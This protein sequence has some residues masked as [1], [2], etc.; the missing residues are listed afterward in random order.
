LVQPDFALDATTV[1]AVAEI[2]RRLDGIPLAIELA[3]ARTKILSINELRR[4]LDDRFRLLVDGARTAPRRLQTLLA[5]IN[6]SFDLL[7]PNERQLLE[8]LSVFAGGWTLEGAVAVGGDGADQ[9]EVLNLLSRLVDKSLVVVEEDGERYRLLETIREYAREHLRAAGAEAAVR[10]RHAGWYVQL[11][12]RLEPSLLGGPLQ[13][14]ALD[15][16]EA[17]NDNLNAALAWSLETPEGADRAMRMCGALYRFWSRRGYWRE[18]YA[19]CTRALAQAPAAGDKA[20][21]AKVLLTA[22]S[23]GNNV[24][25]AET[26]VFLEAAVELG[27]ESGDR[28]TEAVALNNLARVLDWHLELSRARSLLEKARR[29]NRD[30]GNKIPELHNMSNLVNV[31]REQREFAA[32][33]ALAQE[34]LAASRTLGDRWLAAI[35]LYL[36]GRIALDGGQIAAAREFNEQALAIFRELAM[37]DWQSFSLAKLAFLAIA[38]GEP[39]AARRH[40]AEAVD[41]SRS[42][43]GRLNLAECIGTMGVL[44]S[45]IGEHHQAA[46]LWGVAD[47]L[48]G[49][50]FSTDILDR[51]LVSPYDGKSRAALGDAGYA[52]ARKEGQALPR[53]VALDQAVAWLTAKA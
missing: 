4:M 11:A 43:S 24:P 52:A 30:L 47:G 42:F 5:A 34:G 49:S 48:L 26:R 22:G 17:E 3:A 28:A 2:C 18:G 51:E 39:A 7:T 10:D 19:W 37:P 35:F 32:A 14:P 6:W 15:L 38:E 53:E 25:E 50:L 8:R 45:H 36:L 21:R 44:A 27:R 40:L 29:I 33:Q 12:E 41:I 16:L 9:Y 31:L 13:R 23:L 46:R 20:V 1:P